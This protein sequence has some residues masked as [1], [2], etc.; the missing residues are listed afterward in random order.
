MKKAS[1]PVKRSPRVTVVLPGTIRPRLIALA[2]KADRKESDY[3][4]LVLA[5]HLNASAKS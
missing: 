1:K 5:D 4:R 3:I 2:K